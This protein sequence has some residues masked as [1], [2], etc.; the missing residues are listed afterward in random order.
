MYNV[1]TKLIFLNTKQITRDKNIMA[2]KPKKDIYT[3]DFETYYETGK[4]DAY[5]LTNKALN[6]SEYI[7]D[8]RFRAHCLG[9][10]KNAGK[11]RVVYGDAN[12]RKALALIDWKVSGLLCH[13]TAFDGF[14]LSHHYGVVPAY[15]YDTMC[16]ARAAHGVYESASLDHTCKI[17]GLAGKVKGGNLVNTA[18]KVDLTKEELTQLGEYCIDDT[19]DTYD[20]FLKLLPHVPESEMKLIDLTIRMFADPV[21]RLDTPR[22]EAEYL[23]EVAA[24]QAAVDTVKEIATK[25][26][27]VSNDKFAA[28][29]RSLDYEPPMKISTT[30]GKPTYAFAKTDLEFI[31]MLETA[32]P[33]VQALCESRIGTKSSVNETRALRFLN[34]GKDGM[35]IP[36]M[37]NYA[38]AATYR[39]SGGNKMNL[40]NLPRGGELRRSLLAP[41]GHQIVVVDSAQI[42]ARVLAWVAG[43]ED[44]L[45]TFANW[46]AGKGAD[47]YKTMASNIYHKPVEDIDSTERFVGKVATLGLGYGM[48]AAKFADTLAKGAMGPKVIISAD[49]AKGAVNAYRTANLCIRMFWARAEAILYDMA[50]G[51][52]G[53]F[54]PIHWGEDFL[55]L[56]NGLFLRYP[57]LTGDGY[58]GRDGRKRLDNAH[59]E[60]KR[61]AQLYTYGGKLTENIVQALARC[62]VAEQMIAVSEKYRIVSMTHD[63]IIAVAPTRLAKRALGD[64]LTAMKTPPTW[65]KGLPLNAEGG[66]DACYS[67]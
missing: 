4:K 32:P 42:E 31:E 58:I 38:G 37:L 28:L 5:S 44:V 34:A 27:L 16:M 49:D 20:L 43:Q 12:I 30:T 46:D 47:V 64:I 10:R 57:N 7:R 67:K 65:A 21:L 50:A 56:P 26:D 25:E 3:L 60:G 11:T 2:N 45:E 35:P 33:A 62:I 52:T 9:I 15:Y 17:H 66:Y 19:R 1:S 6:M 41:K 18:N 13:N 53:T 39:W 63:E 61:G 24:K 40:Q 22:A 14:I 59:F 51:I 54:G 23:K 36:V 8:P 29:L 55:G 48:G